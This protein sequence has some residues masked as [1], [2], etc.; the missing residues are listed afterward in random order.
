MVNNETGAVLGFFV[1][2]RAFSE[3]ARLRD[4]LP[5]AIPA[6][7]MD[8]ELLAELSKP[9]EERHPELDHLMEE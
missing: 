1:S 9:L 7:E 5:R 4:C 2:A 3:F 8:A 6:W